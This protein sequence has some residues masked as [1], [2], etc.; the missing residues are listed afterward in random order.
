MEECFNTKRNEENFSLQT[1]LLKPRIGDIS[2]V[3]SFICRT[4]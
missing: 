2:R 1:L 3:F 4:E